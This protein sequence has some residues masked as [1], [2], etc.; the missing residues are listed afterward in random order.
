MVFL[1]GGTKLSIFHPQHEI[2]VLRE[3]LKVFS[4]MK[5][6]FMVCEIEFLFTMLDF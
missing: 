5:N 2:L 6:Q 3:I 4:I 1:T